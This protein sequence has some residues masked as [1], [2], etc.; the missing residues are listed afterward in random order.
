VNVHYGFEVLEPF[1]RGLEGRV[2]VTVAKDRPGHVRQHADMSGR[3]AELRLVSGA[4]GSVSIDVEAPAALGEAENMLRCKRER[5][6]DLL[7]QGR[8]PYLK[9][10]SRVLIR[11]ADVL[12]YLEG[13]L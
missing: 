11:R 1:G 2:K 13:R 7:S 10:G 5:V 12:A 9:D 8:L 3:V 4:E 6:Y